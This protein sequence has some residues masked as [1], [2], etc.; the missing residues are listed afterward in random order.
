LKSAL[1]T[2]RI[3]LFLALA[4]A[5]VNGFARFAYALILPLM[6]SDLQWDYA[7]SGWLNTANSLGYGVGGLTG[8]L[9]LRKF[10]PSS[11][12]VA[13]LVGAVITLFLVGVIREFYV[14]LGLR[15]LTGVGSAWVFACGSALVAA[16]YAHDQKQSG[17]AIAIYF[18]GG[19]LGIALSGVVIYPVLSGEMSWP[20]AWIVLGATGALMAILPIVSAL[21]VSANKNVLSDANFP[22]RSFSPIFIAYLLFGVGYIIYMTFVIAWLK[23]M[24]VGVGFTAAL[25]LVVG[26]GAMA[27]GWMW[28]RPMANWWP[29]HT[30]AVATLMTAVGSVLPL[31]S[32]AQPV[33]LISG[34]MVGGSFF[35]VPAAMSVL[36]R[37]TLP[38]SLWATAMNLFTMVFAMGQAIGPVLAGWIADTAGLNVAMLL[39]GAILLVSAGL[40]LCQQKNIYLATPSSN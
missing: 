20:M 12:F 23:E 36:A 26:F 24:R 19:G 25:W 40:A 39:G 34:F 9:L 8:M 37:K 2:L 35:M 28:R 38:Q 4:I 6:R 17:E 10:R 30:F 13:G 31:V 11:L 27:S 16:L 21:K 22:W 1:P 3:A 32:R 7:A 29:T 15:F 5:V 18:A 33:L 14:M